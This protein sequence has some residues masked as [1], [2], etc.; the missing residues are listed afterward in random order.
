MGTRGTLGT[1]ARPLFQCSLCQHL[2][3]GPG[4]ICTCSQLQRWEEVCQEGLKQQQQREPRPPHLRFV[5]ICFCLCSVPLFFLLSSPSSS[6]SLQI[7][8]S[9][10][11]PSSILKAFSIRVVAMVS[12]TLASLHAVVAL[13][14]TRLHVKKKDRKKARLCE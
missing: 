11:P 7:L 3:W 10:T 12:V 9:L 8:P 6:V 2:S 1:G 13:R 5:I 4:A 14:C